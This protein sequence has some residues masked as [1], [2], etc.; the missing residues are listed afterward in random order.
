MSPE[1]HI[2]AHMSLSA[3]DSDEIL[4]AKGGASTAT[5]V[6]IHW[7]GS[8]FIS[9]TSHLHKIF[10][11]THPNVIVLSYILLGLQSSFPPPQKKRVPSCATP[12]SFFYP[13]NPEH[14]RPRC[15]FFFNS[16]SSCC[17]RPNTRQLLDC[18]YSVCNPRHHLPTKHYATMKLHAT[19]YPKLPIIIFPVALRPN[20][21]HSLLIPEV[22]WSHT[23]THHSRYDSSGR[24]IGSSQR[25]LPDNTKHSQQ[26]NIRV[27]DGIRTHDLSRRA[28]AD[29]RLR[30]RGNWDRQTAHNNF[31]NVSLTVQLSIISVINQLNAQILVL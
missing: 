2:R 16:D 28:A 12:S 14:P 27:S 13:Y 29:L 24:V 22:S 15:Y 25:P 23:T 1:K 7:A 8:W 6:A 18:N 19:P 20:A 10:L 5:F 21:G 30:P 17:V 26:T 9:F 3:A 4:I 11:N 31:C